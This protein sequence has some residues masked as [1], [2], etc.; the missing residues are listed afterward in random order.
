VFR[1]RIRSTGIRLFLGL[2]DPH[3]DWLVRVT[4]PRIQIRIR[5]RGS[6]QCSIPNLDF[7]SADLNTTWVMIIFNV[8]LTIKCVKE[9]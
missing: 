4:D 2:P 7:V 9:K 6:A 8:D 3:P 1:I 5:I